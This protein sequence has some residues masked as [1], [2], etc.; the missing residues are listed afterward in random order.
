MTSPATPN[1][2]TRQQPHDNAPQAAAHPKRTS[3]TAH[4]HEATLEFG[5]VRELVAGKALCGLGRA[6]VMAMAPMADP[7]RLAEA[8]GLTREMLRLMEERRDPPLGGLRDLSDEIAKVRRDRSMLEPEELLRLKDFCE[9]AGLVRR[10]FEPLQSDTPGLHALAMPMHGLPGLVRSIDQK[11]APDATVR[12]NASEALAGIRNELR[13]AERAVTDTLSR[14]VRE[15]FASGD[16]QDDFYTLRNDRYVLPVKTSNRGKVPGIIHG[17]S[18]TEETVFIEPFAVLEQTNRLAELRLREKEEVYRILLRVAAS[19]RDEINPLLTDLEILSEFD[20]IQ[21]KAAFGQAHNCAFPTMTGMDMPMILHRAH[22]PLLYAANPSASRAL[23]LALD[24]TDR[25]LVIT[26]PNA[27]GKTTALK[28]LGLTALMV[29]SGVP[30]PL[31]PRS[32]LPVFANILADIGDEQDL[33]EGFSTFSAHMRR[34]ANILKRADGPTL[35][36]LDELGSAT[37]PGEGGALAIGILET[38]AARG[39]LV[40]SSSHLGSLKTWAFSHPAGRNASFR[41]GEQD[42]RPTFRL[43]MDL[44]GISEAFVIA[45]REGIPEEVLARAR[46]F[47][48]EGDRDVTELLMSLQDK[49]AKAAKMLE[50]AEALRAEANEKTMELDRLDAKLRDDRRRFRAEILAD[51]DKAVMDLKAKVESM[52]AGLPGK[53]ELLAAK[54]ALEAEAAE[55]EGAKEAA[56][57]GAPGGKAGRADGILRPGDRVYL[58]T[59]NEPGVVSSIDTDRGVA[60]VMIGRL[61][62]SARLGDIDLVKRVEEIEGEASAGGLGAG[63]ARTTGKTAVAAGGAVHFK[64]PDNPESMLDLHGMRVEE[65][66]ERFEKFLDQAL[67]AGFAHVKIMH[68]Q[69]T[70]RLGKALHNHFRRH[71]NVKAFRYAEPHEGGGGVTVVEFK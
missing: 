69:G 54:Q 6:R 29:Q 68:G 9:V 21:A 37:D 56:R 65:A 47:A 49:E 18:N 24:T 31:D 33:L 16:L 17:S 51:R 44:P 28:T 43:T 40:V 67:V 52:I 8:I 11:I 7:A 13:G 1:T 57:R 23:D 35:V 3:A 14:M 41:L 4:F 15:F 12:D 26:G 20:F 62:A 60:K 53:R 66:L 70:G 38:L 59:L 25:V 48:P 46:A 30:A 39:C 2:T 32:R 34:I 5:A 71:P 50:S 10:H 55:V 64:R 42:R 22:H 63:D 58:R 19:I 61:M 36:L 45:E 27:G